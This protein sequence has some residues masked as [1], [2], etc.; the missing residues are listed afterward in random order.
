MTQL[1]RIHPDNPQIRL[2]RQAIAV[3]DEGGVVALPTD[4]GYALACHLDDKDAVG[5][6]RTIRRLPEEH[7]F[8]LLVRNLSELS[9]YTKIN[10]NIYKILKEYT[11][12]PYTFI[13]PATRSVPKRLMHPKRKTVGI[14]IPDHPIIQMFLEEIGEPLMSVSLWLPG[15]VEPITSAEYIY[16]KLNRQIDVIIDTGF[17]SNEPTTIIDFTANNDGIPCVLRVGKGNPTPFLPP[18]ERPASSTFSQ[19]CQKL[20]HTTD[21]SE[22]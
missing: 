20:N 12:G 19:I 21:N 1:F 6:I 22:D 3:L 18:G 7:H 4:S 10:N 17:C 14:R 5:R 13:L 9:S 8:T 2:L 11:P 15:E 16:S